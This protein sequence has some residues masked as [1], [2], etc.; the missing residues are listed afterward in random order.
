MSGFTVERKKG[1]PVSIRFGDYSSGVT[2]VFT[3]SRQSLGIDGWYDSM[4]G[5]EGGS[6]SLGEF[7]RVF[8]I[9]PRMVGRALAE[10]AKEDAPDMNRTTGRYVDIAPTGECCPNCKH[11]FT[12]SGAPDFVGDDEG[13][14][15][16][17]ACRKGHQVEDDKRCEEWAQAGEGEG[18]L[19]G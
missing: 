14:T 19:C 13:T 1:Q 7:C 10:V 11:C 4:V 15:Y 8:G 16:Y 2:I 17:P 12:T 6:L 3:K 5:I 18:Y 9:T